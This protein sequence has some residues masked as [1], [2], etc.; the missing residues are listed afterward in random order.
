MVQPEKGFG[1]IAVD[2]G[3]QNDD[4][5]VHYKAIDMPGFKTLEEGQRVEFETVQGHKARRPTRSTPS[6]S[7]LTTGPSDGPPR[8]APPGF[9]TVDPGGR[10]AFRTAGTGRIDP[11]PKFPLGSRLRI[12]HRNPG[13]CPL[14][15]GG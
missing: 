8:N 9:G 14:A 6:D 7:P 10:C 15:W 1:F 3:G 4:V 5:F 2:G 12:Q 13:D 11:P